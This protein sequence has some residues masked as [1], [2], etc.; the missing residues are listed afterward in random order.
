MKIKN[1]F[2]IS[3]L[4]SIWYSIRFKGKIFIGRGCKLI[5]SQNAKIKI[6]NGTLKLG[7]SYNI[8]NKMI[9]QIEKKGQI[10]VNG[11]VSIGRGCKVVIGEDAKLEINNNSYINE[12]SK[13]VCMKKITIGENCAIAWNVNILDTD[14]HFIIKNGIIKEREKEVIIHNKV[15]IG[16]NSTILKGSIIRENSIIS[17]N[18]LVNTSIQNNTLFYNEKQ[19][20]GYDW[21]I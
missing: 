10:I 7:I 16:C 17:A 5:I 15:W 12:C 13:I 2:K 4:K 8:P 14:Y 6:N 18:S 20:L 1:I 21:K 3:I 9:V 11:N 19:V